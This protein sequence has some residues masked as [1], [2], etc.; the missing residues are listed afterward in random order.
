MDNCMLLLDI[1]LQSLIVIVLRLGDKFLPTTD[2]V[3]LLY[4]FLFCTPLP[5]LEPIH[6]L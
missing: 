5:R 6:R 2:L 4:V 3:N 1:A